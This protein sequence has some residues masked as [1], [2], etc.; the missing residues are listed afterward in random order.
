MADQKLSARTITTVT[1]GGYVHIII[2]SG[3]P[4]GF[5]SYRIAI[6]EL[7]GQTKTKYAAQAADFTVDLDADT[8]VERIDFFFVTGSPVV[9][10]GTVITENQIISGRTITTVKNSLNRLGDAKSYFKLAQTLYFT[11]TGGTIDV[12]ITYK[13]S[14]NT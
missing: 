4:S 10:V 11:I 3:S 12:I 5:S 2:P 1:E 13:K 8:L 9:K 6:P 7:I 14:Y